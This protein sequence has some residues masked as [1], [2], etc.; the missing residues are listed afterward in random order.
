MCSCDLE[1][2]IWRLDQDSWIT[3]Q[4]LT[5]P[6]VRHGTQSCRLKAT[7]SNDQMFGVLLHSF[8]LHH[9]PTCVGDRSG[10]TIFQIRHTREVDKSLKD[11]SERSSNDRRMEPCMIQADA[12]APSVWDLVLKVDE[13][14]TSKSFSQ[15]VA[16]N[17]YILFMR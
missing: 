5:G 15:V 11:W 1:R 4:I 9:F 13:T 16:K 7:L 12:H 17:I 8:Q 10:S 6:T 2:E 14:K 3:D